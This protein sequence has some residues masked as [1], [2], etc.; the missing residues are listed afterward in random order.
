MCLIRTTVISEK[1]NYPRNSRGAVAPA[2]WRR[3]IPTTF[4]FI[5]ILDSAVSELLRV[6][7]ADGFPSIILLP[8]KK[9]DSES[10]SFMHPNSVSGRVHSF[11]SLWLSKDFVL[12]YLF[13]EIS[14]HHW[15]N[16]GPFSRP[17][18]KWKEPMQHFGGSRRK[19]KSRRHYS[20]PL[21][22]CNQYN[23]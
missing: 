15:C 4:Q 11:S 1:H 10:H 9:G 19:H 6:P 22:V 18:N 13:L 3:K 23:L 2:E 12:S 14:S 7:Q 16:Y 5:T 8:R 17:M 21:S 20:A